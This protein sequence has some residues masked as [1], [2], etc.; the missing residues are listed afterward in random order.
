MMMRP[1]RLARLEK[2]VDKPNTPIEK[3]LVKE[4][5]NERMATK[6]PQQTIDDRGERHND[7]VALKSGKGQP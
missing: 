2:E 5:Y 1:Q 4:V 6:R 3:R 7:F